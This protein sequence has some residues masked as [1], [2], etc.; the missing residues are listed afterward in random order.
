MTCC[1]IQIHEIDYNKYITVKRIT[2]VFYGAIKK[3][4]SGFINRKLFT[5]VSKPYYHKN[6]NDKFLQCFVLE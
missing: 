5:F 1:V 3:Y 6:E 2:S 4:Y